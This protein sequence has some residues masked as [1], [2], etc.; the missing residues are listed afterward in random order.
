LPSQSRFPAYDSTAVWDNYVKFLYYGSSTEKPDSD[1]RIYNKVGNAYG[2]LIDAACFEQVR[3]QKKF[4]LSA[5]VYCNSDEIFNDDR[6]DY[7]SIGYPFLRSLG[8]ILY[9]QAMSSR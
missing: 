6:Y 8:R 4:L 9:Q 5:V 1:I 7:D 2:F 3:T